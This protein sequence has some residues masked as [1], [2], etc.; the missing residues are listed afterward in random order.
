MRLFLAERTPRALLHVLS[1]AAADGAGDD[2]IDTRS[3]L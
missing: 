1:D 2:A 3:F